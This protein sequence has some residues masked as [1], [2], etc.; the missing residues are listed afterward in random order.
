MILLY[1]TALFRLIRL[2]GKRE[3]VTSA[4]LLPSKVRVE[5]QFHGAN[6]CEAQNTCGFYDICLICTSNPDYRGSARPLNR[7]IWSL[8]SGCVKFSNR[9]LTAQYSV[10]SMANFRFAS[11]AI[12][13]RGWGSSSVTNTLAD[14]CRV[15]EPLQAGLC[16]ITQPNNSVPKVE[17]VQPTSPHL[18]LPMKR[19]K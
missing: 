4:S 15:C 19:R 6:P 8:R 10:V 18:R 1:A 13:V 2:Q 14:E 7:R 11:M 17:V 16:T 5:K 3:G 9:P 12:R